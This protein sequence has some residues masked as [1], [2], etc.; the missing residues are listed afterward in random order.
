[1]RLLEEKSK[2][3]LPREIETEMTEEIEEDLEVIVEEET[4]IE[5]DVILEIDPKDASTAKR[6]VISHVIAPNVKVF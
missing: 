4:L 2:L 6:K 1:M 3:N 5:A